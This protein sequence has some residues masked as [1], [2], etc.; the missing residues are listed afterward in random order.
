MVVSPCPGGN[1]SPGDWN[2]GPHLS[3][4]GGKVVCGSVEDR[5]D[6]AWTRDSQLLLATV[7][8]G[9]SLGDLYQR[10]QRFGAATGQDSS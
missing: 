8:G 3:Q 2:Y 9:P 10:W 1:A 6:V 7:N 5:A 4:P